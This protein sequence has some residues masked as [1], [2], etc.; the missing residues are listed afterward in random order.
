ML[1]TLDINSA[2]CIT[3]CD[4]E[5]Y[6]T[7]SI[8]GK[9]EMEIPVSYNSIAHRNLDQLDSGLRPFVVPDSSYDDK[10][11]LMMDMCRREFYKS[12]EIL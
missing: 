1:E 8:L 7:G 3:E 4:K 9:S 10:K 5:R 12:F 2:V 11:G 6:L